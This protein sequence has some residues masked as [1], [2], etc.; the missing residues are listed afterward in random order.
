[1][2][3]FL[4]LFKESPKKYLTLLSGLIY[5]IPAGSIGVTGTASPYYMSYLQNKTHSGLA[6]YP[7]TIYLLTLQL[8]FNACGAV[9]VGLIMTKLKISLK[10]MAFVGP[11][12]IRSVL[13]NR[14]IFYNSFS[15][16]LFCIQLSLEFSFSYVISY[17]TLQYS[18]I[19]FCISFG[20]IFGK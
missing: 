15:I 8:V 2:S 5:L 13:S 4:V 19:L 10:R 6:R 20:L 7:N 12:L 3:Q 17:F 1:M 16:L 9:M 11:I 14:P 18:F